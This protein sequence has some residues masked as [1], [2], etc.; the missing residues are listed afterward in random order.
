MMKFFLLF[1]HKYFCRSQSSYIPTV[2]GLQKHHSLKTKK[3]TMAYI[4]EELYDKKIT[5]EIAAHYKEILR[6][7]GEDPQREGLVKTP[8]RVAKAV[9]YPWFTAGWGGDPP[10]RHVQG[11]VSAD[12]SC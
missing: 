11:R 6:L 9:P 12:G 8:E 2:P 5:E 4:K 1:L 3:T 7:L 10:Q